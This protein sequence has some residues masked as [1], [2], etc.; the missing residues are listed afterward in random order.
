LKGQE[1]SNGMVKLSEWKARWFPV[2]SGE[3]MSCEIIWRGKEGTC[4]ANVTYMG[5]RLRDRLKTAN[6]DES[7]RRLIQLKLAVERGDYQKA[8][9]TFDDLVASYTPRSERKALILRV[10]LLP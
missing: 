9:K 3:V 6:R 2:T 10:H 5:I 1:L 8:K 7:Q 4:Y